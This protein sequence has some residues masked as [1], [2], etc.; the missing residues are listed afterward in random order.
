MNKAVQNICLLVCLFFYSVQSYSQSSVE[1][2]KIEAAIAS[3]HPL[4]T[5]A[6]IDILKQGG[7]AFDAAI[8]VTAALAV[9][10]R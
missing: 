6:G 7:N 10:A 9:V 3:A 4:A 5:R 1:H 8:A 2:P